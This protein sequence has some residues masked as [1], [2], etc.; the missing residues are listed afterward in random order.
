MD[1]ELSHQSTFLF[2]LLQTK[3]SLKNITSSPVV[4]SGSNQLVK[5]FIALDRHGPKSGGEED[6]VAGSRR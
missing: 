2:A 5:L 6:P 4:E 3:F 1:A